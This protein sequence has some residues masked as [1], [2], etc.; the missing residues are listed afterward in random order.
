VFVVFVAED[1][2]GL[3]GGFNLYAYVQ[4]NPMTWTDPRGLD[5]I[6]VG[7]GA[8]GVIVAGGAGSAGVYISNNPPDVGVYI[9][10]EVGAGVDIGI[11]AQV[12][13][14]VG[15]SSGMEDP[16][17]NINAAGGRIAG[18]IITDAKT[19]DIVGG[20]IGPAVS[21]VCHLRSNIEVGSERCLQVDI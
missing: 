3:A 21:W 7:G 10:G 15:P 14:I 16:T 8:S 5:N 1:P 9:T 4:G 20:S 13:Y 19:G 2:I 11:S 12:S 18:G 6:L 17:V